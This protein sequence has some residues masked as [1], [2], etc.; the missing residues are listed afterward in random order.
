MK[1]FE[2]PHTQK[3]RPFFGKVVRVQFADDVKRKKG[4]KGKDVL[5]D[6]WHVLYDDGD[7]EDYNFLEVLDVLEY[8]KKQQNTVV[9]AIL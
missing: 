5:E 6:W 3:P 2:D 7:Q 9:P 4:G 1:D 8:A